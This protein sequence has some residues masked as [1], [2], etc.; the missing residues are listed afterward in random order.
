MPHLHFCNRAGFR[1]NAAKS[2]KLG[3]NRDKGQ[4]PGL[5]RPNQDTWQLCDIIDTCAC[6]EAAAAETWTNS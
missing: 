3:H 4:I 6:H 2:G 5:S 1:D